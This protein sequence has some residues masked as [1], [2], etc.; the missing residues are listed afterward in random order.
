LLIAPA[1][2]PS[3]GIGNARMQAVTFRRHGGPDVL[4]VEDVPMP[5]PGPDEILVKVLACSVNRVP[6][7]VVRASARGMAKLTFP[8]VLGIDPAG[9][10]VAVGARVLGF[11]LG[12]RVVIYPLLRCGECDQCRSGSGE[13]YCRQYRVIGVH[14]WGGYAEYVKVPAENV[15]PIPMSVSADAASALAWS[16][17]TAWHGL[18]TTARITAGDVAV[19]TAAGSGVGVAACQIA[20][21]H[22][23]RVIAT[24]DSDAKLERAQAVGAQAGVNASDPGWADRVLALTDGRG[25]DIVFDVTGKPGWQDCLRVLARRGRMLSC[26]AAGGHAVRMD[27]GDLHRNHNTLFFYEGG[28]SHELR[29]LVRLV[30]SGKLEPVIDSRFTLREVRT[31]QQRLAERANFG[32]IILTP[33]A[34]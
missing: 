28:G 26:G 23:A 15:I 2:S 22:G 4:R 9:E 32:K 12:H 20:R 13:N 10:V 7:L 21:L 27:L 34:H 17:T 8:H 6:D 1:A 29:H 33:Q 14:L 30:A 5:V 31:A 24:A 19:V 18:V 16:Y 11:P 25:A 3:S